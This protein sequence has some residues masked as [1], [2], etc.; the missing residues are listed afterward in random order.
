MAGVI[1]IMCEHQDGVIHPV[2]DEM[3]NCAAGISAIRTSSVTVV[4]AG[5]T[6]GAAAP[7]GT[8]MLVINSPALREYTSEG[9]E[10][11]AITA[12][13]DLQ[14][15][16][17]II[18][19]TSQGYDYAP[20]LAAFLDASCVTSVS[21][22]ENINGSPA[23]RRSGFHGKLDMLYA[24]ARPPVVITVLPGAFPAEV[25]DAPPG[26]TRYVSADIGLTATAGVSRAPS[27]GRNIELENAEVI[28]SAGR[29]LGN[30][31]NLGLI[32]SMAALFDRSAV[33]GSRVACDR[34]WIE[35]NAQVGITGKNVSPRLYVACGISGSQQH[36]AGMKGSK[37]VVSINRD[38]D[39]AIFRY[40]D[41]CVVEDLEKFIPEFIRA[42]EEHKP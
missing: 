13:E 37:T 31:E 19:H 18:P 2:T 8:D 12:A 29:G 22:V 36:V 1:M 4:M 28:I 11:A 32:K 23:F 42:A 5:N 34:G 35:H 40:S 15:D 14:P 27:S 21:A 38:P 10:K 24:C 39:A 3:I 33:A 25:P 41:I 16:I 30:E 7:A 20:R 17:I 26:R 9:L 6:E